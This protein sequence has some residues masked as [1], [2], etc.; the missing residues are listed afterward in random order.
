MKTNVVITA[1]NAA[2]PQ[3]QAAQ[4]STRPLPAAWVPDASSDGG[5]WPLERWR[6]S[7]AEWYPPVANR[8]GII[9]L[10]PGKIERP[11]TFAGK[12]AGTAW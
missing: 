5:W 1:L 3:S 12:T 2:E 10:T 6:C 4:A 9:R 8:A 7:Y 11:G